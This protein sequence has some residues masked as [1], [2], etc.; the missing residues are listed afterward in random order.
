MAT[1]CPERNRS[2]LSEAVK[3]ALQAPC[4]NGGQPVGG[5]P[6]GFDGERAPV[7]ATDDERLLSGVT[8]RKEANGAGAVKFSGR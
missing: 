5:R 8:A 1:S 4:R 6:F 2:G 3:S 7:E